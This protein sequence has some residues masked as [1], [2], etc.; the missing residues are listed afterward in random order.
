M[1]T[2]PFVGDRS[3]LFRCSI[4]FSLVHTQYMVLLLFVCYWFII[5]VFSCIPFLP[6]QF[7][8]RF[9][10]PC[11]S[12][13][14]DGSLTVPCFYSQ[15]HFHLPVT[16]IVH[17]SWLRQLLVYPVLSY[18][19]FSTLLSEDIFNVDSHKYETIL[20]QGLWIYALEILWNFVDFLSTDCSFLSADFG[21]SVLDWW[22]L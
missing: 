21:S 11:S 4:S 22:G 14:D 1:W 12:Y 19:P 7:W 10:F 15:L 13:M 18:S 6:L 3:C 16:L 9:M 2:Q 17:I 5:L 8:W 20:L